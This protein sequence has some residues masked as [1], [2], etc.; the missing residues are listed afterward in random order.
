[1]TELG[2]LVKHLRKNRG[3]TLQATSGRWSQS[4]MSRFENGEIDLTDDVV[5]ELAIPL[6]LDYEDLITRN[7]L[8]ESSINRWEYLA[9]EQWHTE[10]ARDLLS[11]LKQLQVENAR[12]DLLKTAITVVSELLDVHA[13]HRRIMHDDVVRTLNDYLS[14]LSEFSR[15]DG[16]LFSVCTEYVPVQ[17]GWRWVLHQIRMLE[18]AGNMQATP[19]RIRRVISFCGTVAERA[20]LEGRLTL[21][22]SIVDEMYRLKTYIPEN[23]NQQFSMAI[24]RALCVDLTERTVVSHDKFVAVLKTSHYIFPTDVHRSMVQYTIEQ[25]WA[26]A[27]DFADDPLI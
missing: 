2:D 23:A 18:P 10:A 8:R 13:Q 17:I 26:T 4:S 16:I 22:Q 24:S 14:K 6:G 11:N 5:K 9:S 1:M 20:A 12:N 7:I 25:G 19:Q 15:I 27:E 3:L 21:M